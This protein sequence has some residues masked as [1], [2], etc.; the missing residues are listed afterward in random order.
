MISFSESSILLAGTPSSALTFRLIKSG[1][2]SI[3]A[4]QELQTHSTLG[5][6]LLAA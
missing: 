2:L 5:S 3:L 6:V 1:H 4:N